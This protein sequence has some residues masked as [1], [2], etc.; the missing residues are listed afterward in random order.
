MSDATAQ[1]EELQPAILNM[2]QGI[3]EAHVN[4]IA[5]PDI[6]RSLASYTRNYYLALTD[7][8]FT[9]AQA[10]KIVIAGGIPSPPSMK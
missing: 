8:G 7:Q 1:L 2:V 9:E 3:M 6:A 5:R 10:L 4:L